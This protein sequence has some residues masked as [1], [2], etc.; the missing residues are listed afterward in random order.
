MR[1]GLQDNQAKLAPQDLRDHLA[2]TVVPDKWD[3]LVSP[4][5]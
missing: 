1:P 5:V 3:P 2:M 4:E